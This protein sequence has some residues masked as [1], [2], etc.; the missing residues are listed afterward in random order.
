MSLPSQAPNNREGRPQRDSVQAQQE[1]CAGTPSHGTARGRLKPPR[2]DNGGYV[3]QPVV[4]LLLPMRL[5]D[6]R[7][8]G[9]VG[10]V[11][12]RP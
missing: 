3:N 8:A 11:P 7:H 9:F 1:T 4:N 6:I 12:Q 5:Q 10:S 2:S